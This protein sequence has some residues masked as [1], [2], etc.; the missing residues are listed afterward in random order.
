MDVYWTFVSW[1]M[2]P[3]F[4]VN[5][6]HKRNP[7]EMEHTFI[8]IFDRSTFRTAFDIPLP[9]YNLLIKLIVNNKQMTAPASMH[10]L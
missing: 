4:M 8:W 9:Q 1:K 3:H 10:E 7:Q 6:M 5:P 2:K